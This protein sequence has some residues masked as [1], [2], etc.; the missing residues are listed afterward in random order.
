MRK[1]AFNVLTLAHTATGLYAQARLAHLLDDT[2]L[3]SLAVP[4]ATQIHHMHPFRAH[5]AIARGHS[6]RVI[7]IIG[8]SGEIAL[9]QAHNTTV[10]KVNCRIKNHV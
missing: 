5:L 3:T 1:Q 2:A 9:E 4:R 10:E 7:A 8:H 6:N